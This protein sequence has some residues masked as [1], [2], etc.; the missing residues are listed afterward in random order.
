MYRVRLKLK[1]STSLV[2]QTQSQ[3]NCLCKSTRKGPRYR[4]VVLGLPFEVVVV[5]VEVIARIKDVYML[6]RPGR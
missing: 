4:R 6:D 2:T 1:A 3:T 5:V